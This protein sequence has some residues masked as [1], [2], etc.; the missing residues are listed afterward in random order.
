VA[1]NTILMIGDG[2]GWEVARAAA[3]QQQINAGKTGDRLSDF[4][5]NGEGSGLNFQKLGGYGIATTYGTTIADSKGVFNTGNSALDDTVTATG[6]SPGRAGFSFDPT[7]NPGNKATGGATTASGA[8]GNLVGYDPTKG[9]AN[10]WTPG[11][12]KEYIKYSYPDSANTATTLYTGVKSYNNAIGVDIFE[13]SLDGVLAQAARQGKATGLVTSVPIDHATPGAAAANV[14]RRNKYDEAYPAL[15]NILQQ[16]LRVYQPNVLLGGGHPLSSPADLLP[17]GVEPNRDNTYIKPETYAELSKNPNATGANSNRYGYTF[18]ERGKDAAQ[19]LADT[20]KKIDPDQDGHLLGVYGARGQNGNLPVSSAN[21]DYSTTGLDM[22]SVNTSKGLKQ[23]FTRPLLPGETDASFIAKERNENPTLNQLTKASLDTLGKDKDGFWLMVEGGD[24]D[25]GLHDNNIDN[26]IGATLDFDK[27]VGSVI[28]WIEKNGG[29]EQNELIVTADHDHYLTLNKDFPKLL[30]EQG[31]DK[32]TAVDTSAAAGHYWGSKPETVKIAD[33]QDPTKQIDDPESGK[34][35]WGNHSNRPVPVYYQGADTE[36]LTTDVGKGYVNYG[37][38]VPGIPGLID[39]TTIYR[40]Q[41]NGVN[42]RGTDGGTLTTYNW[43][44]RPSLGITNTF[45]PKDTNKTVPGQEIKLGGFS[46]LKFEGVAANGNLKFITHTDRGPNAENVDLLKDVP[47]KEKPFVLPSFQPEI[48]RFELNATT[49]K[50]NLTQRIK[51]TRPDG[52]ALTGLPNLQAGAEGQ[53]YTDEIP[54]DLF[55]NRLPNDPLGADLEGI[56]V[57]KD[58][59]FWLADEYRP[60]IYHFDANGKLIDRLIPKGSPTADGTFG[61]PILPEVYAQ[62]RSNRGFEGVAIDGDKVYAFMQSGLDNPDVVDDA[63]SKASG[64]LRIVEYD[65]KTKAVTGEY[66]YQLNDVKIADKLGDATALGNGKFLVAERDSN[67]TVD[68][69]KSVFEIDISKA[70][71]I[72]QPANIAGVPAGKTIDQLTAAELNTAKIATASKKLVANASALGYTGVEKLE[73]LTVVDNKTLAIINDNDFGIG[74]T[75]IAGDGK[76]EVNDNAPVK[77]G[78][79]SLN[80][81][82]KPVMNAQGTTNLPKDGKTSA[83]DKMVLP[84][85]D[86]NSGTNNLLDLRAEKGQVK[87]STTSPDSARNNAVGFYRIDD[88]T[89]KIGN[90]KPGDAGYIEA[91]LKQ[92]LVSINKGADKDVTLASGALY[93]PYLIANG[94][95]E[96][97]FAKNLTNQSGDKSPQAYFS[98]IGANPDR[99]EHIRALGDGKFGFEDAFG[100]GDL[101]FNDTVLQVNKGLG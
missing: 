27:S 48:D 44:D 51:L 53:A 71:N 77:L 98:F 86:L 80:Q 52:K 97:F 90:L 42:K 1:K 5:T 13:Q 61:T 46:G 59:T 84:V 56:A 8:K 16:E 85:K 20:A 57:A 2:M 64:N 15:D 11:T 24:I 6:A 28:D 31:A 62:R 49:G 94:T 41:A 67:A 29:W 99:A 10:P 66:L 32:L 54:I 14:N 39:Q 3:I 18:L 35:G 19:V 74:L 45:N 55:G 25:W 58:G 50:I 60:S 22:F 83:G 95:V 81:P 92:S 17:N 100:G 4:Y 23:D 40:A 34:Y 68:S 82:I 7:F 73:G 76:V 89:G 36:V 38:A 72:N 70:T 101:K 33:P 21:G 78:L 65:T 75:S 30:R 87:V 26:A 79:I 96:D 37:T 43:D 93:A 91:A 12:D 69:F 88:A 47:G 63:N 9:G